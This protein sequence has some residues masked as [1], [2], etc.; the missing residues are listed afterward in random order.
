[1]KLRSGYLLVLVFLLRCVQ[2]TSQEAMD[3]TALPSSYDVNYWVSVPAL[4]IGLYVTTEGHERVNDRALLSEALLNSLD[5]DVVP[6][7]DRIALRQDVSRYKRALDVSDFGIHYF[8]LAPA[9]LFIDKD[10]RRD[11]LDIAVVYA[12]TQ[13]AVLNVYNYTFLGPT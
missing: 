4:A 11:W 7:F 5:P 10:M 13:M 8:P 6:G 1:M 3:T 12:E 2:I 9:L